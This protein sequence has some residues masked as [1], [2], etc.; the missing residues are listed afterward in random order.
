[1]TVLNTKAGAYAVAI[2]AAAAVVYLLGRRVVAEAGEAAAAVGRAVDPT[3][4]QNIF[5]RGVN[6][7]G[8][9]LTGERDFSLGGWLYDV[10]NP[11]PPPEPPRFPEGT[12]DNPIERRFG[13]F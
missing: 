7:V 13:L 1:M 6:R 11:T 2:I 3:S 4:D 10:F 8:E 12:P 9:V 5:Y